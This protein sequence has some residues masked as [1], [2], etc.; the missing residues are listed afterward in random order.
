MEQSTTPITGTCTAAEILLSLV[1][2]VGIIFGTTL[3]FFFLLW[4]YRL[5]REVI[6][7][8]KYEP[9]FF[10]NIRVLSLLFGSLSVAT[11]IP[12]TVL[13]VVM[14]GVSYSLLG[15]LIPL[16]TGLGLFLF[17]YLYRENS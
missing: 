17:Y 7:S 8:G 2:M 1:P 9:A 13:L 10:R 5:R 12:L 16:S 6:R 11:G 14:N 4:Q 15:G 3:M